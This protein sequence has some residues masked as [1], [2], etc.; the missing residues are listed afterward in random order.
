MMLDSIDSNLTTK[1]MKYDFHKI[2]VKF[3]KHLDP[4]LPFSI[5]YTAIHV[6]MKTLC[7]NSV[8]KGRKLSTR[9]EECSE[10]SNRQYLF[11]DKRQCQLGHPITLT[12]VL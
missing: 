11:Q 4:G 8:S 7:Q 6:T 10:E 9:Q 3:S 1:E 2:C 5:V 12:I